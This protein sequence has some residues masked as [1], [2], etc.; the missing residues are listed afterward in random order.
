M[1]NVVRLILF[2]FIQFVGVVRLSFADDVTHPL[3][4]LNTALLD[5]NNTEAQHI[6]EGDIKNENN[7][8]EKFG[9][10]AVCKTLDIAVG[11]ASFDVVRI[12]LEKGADTECSIWDKSGDTPLMSAY[13]SGNREMV[14]FLVKGGADVNFENKFGATTFWVSV[15][16]GD[17]D[18]IS[19]FLKHN[20]FLEQPGRYPDPLREKDGIVMNLTPLMVAAEGGHY[21]VVKILIDA[22]AFLGIQDSEGRDARGYALKSGN[23]NIVTLIDGYL[24]ALENKK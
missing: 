23:D 14:K 9:E 11:H 22:G 4:K 6:L 16:E 8:I 10:F 13:M 12:L 15:K 1:L 3:Y 2:L 7:L 24:K 5:N 18:Y 21:K 17:L 19:F 20:A